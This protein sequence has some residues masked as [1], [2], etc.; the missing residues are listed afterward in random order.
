MMLLIQLQNSLC[1]V[2]SVPNQKMVITNGS[3]LLE[4][5]RNVNWLNQCLL[6]VLHLS[7]RSKLASLKLLKLLTKKLLMEKVDKIPKKKLRVHHDLSF[8]DV[9]LKLVSM[10]KLY[11]THKLE[12]YNDAFHWLKIITSIPGIGEIY[13]LDYS[14]NMTQQN[15]FECQSLHFSKKQFSLHCTVKHLPDS[16]EYIHHLS[17]VMTHNYAFTSTVLKYLIAHSSTNIIRI[18]SNSCAT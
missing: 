14:E 5:A 6:D 10:K 18:K 11:I 2:A 4:N 16:Q 8:K 9:Y 12:V 15:K 3:V 7:R 1:T 13:H 17:N